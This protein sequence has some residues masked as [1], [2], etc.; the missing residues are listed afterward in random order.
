MEEL[1]DG[2]LVVRFNPTLTLT[3]RFRL[4]VVRTSLVV[5]VLVRVASC[6]SSCRNNFFYVLLC[7][8]LGRMLVGLL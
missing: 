5:S 6:A 4:V 7:F 1:T 8:I 3:L 2:S